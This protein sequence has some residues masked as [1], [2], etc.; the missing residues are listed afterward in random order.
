[1]DLPEIESCLRPKTREDLPF[2]R[3]DTRFVAGGTWLYSEAQPGVRH[4]VDLHSLGWPDLERSEAGVTLGATCT[5][6]RLLAEA[7]P[8][9]WPAC[10]AF[11]AATRALSASYK[12]THAATVGG[13]L[14]LALPIGT[15]APL[16][17]LLN[18]TY[19]VW[20]PDGTTVSWPARGFQTGKRTTRLK[21]GD[22]LRSIRLE[23][24]SLY[25]PV[26]FRAVGYGGYGPPV[27]L[28]AS[29]RLA[30]GNIRLVIAASVAAPILL[31]WETVPT[32]KAPLVAA[33]DRAIPDDLWIEDPLSPAVYRRARSRQLA[34]EVMQPWR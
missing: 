11:E 1:M 23:A 20:R 18:A 29:T 21:Q 16:M 27:A 31:E 26:H 24:E 32:G 19:T 15:L 34:E 6:S 4:L 28:A 14:C 17:V 3:R 10:A 33:L 5:L 13:N 9:A 7:W 8:A 30:S 2:P 25:A 22:L 12:V